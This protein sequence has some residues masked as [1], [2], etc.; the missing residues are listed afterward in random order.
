[1]GRATDKR[2]FQKVKERES[3]CVWVCV[4]VWV[5]VCDGTQYCRLMSPNVLSSFDAN[6]MEVSL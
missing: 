3:V 1:M 6:K 4:G 2:N 5:C